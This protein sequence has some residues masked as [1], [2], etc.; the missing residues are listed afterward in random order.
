MPAL[1]GEGGFAH[2]LMVDLGRY[3]GKAD[4]VFKL[5]GRRV[6]DLV[7]IVACG[8]VGSSGLRNCSSGDDL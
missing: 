7:G 3:L 5:L 2:S 8:V 4:V 1:T 6:E